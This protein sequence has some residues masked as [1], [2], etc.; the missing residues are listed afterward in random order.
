MEPSLFR[1]LEMKEPGDVSKPG[2]SFVLVLVCALLLLLSM[3]LS[4]SAFDA[5]VSLLLCECLER[6]GCSTGEWIWWTSK[7]SV[8]GVVKSGVTARMVEFSDSSKILPCLSR[9]DACLLVL[10]C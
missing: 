9:E 5:E 1:V 3:V 4:S 10:R 8:W 7:E 2:S 6:L